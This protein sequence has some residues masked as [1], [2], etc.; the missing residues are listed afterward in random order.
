[1]KG[2]IMKKLSMIVMLSTSL[3]FTLGIL[4]TAADNPLVGTWKMNPSKSKSMEPLDKSATWKLEVQGNNENDTFDGVDAEG[5]PYHVTASPKY[6]GKDYPISG[7]PRQDTVALSKVDANTVEY[8]VKKTGKEIA[9]G[10]VTVSK[11][12]KTMTESGKSRNP[13]GQETSY[14]I[15]WE[16]Q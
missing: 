10:R 16:K 15:I 8:V 13:K 2:E 11:D 12:G 4:A 14:T 7:N 9:K 5:K 1:M 6:D 3:I